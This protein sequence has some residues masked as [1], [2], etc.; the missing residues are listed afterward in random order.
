MFPF[1]AFTSADA[2]AL[3][4]QMASE[5]AVD[6]VDTVDIRYFQASIWIILDL[7]LTVGLFPLLLVVITAGCIC[8]DGGDRPRKASSVAADPRAIS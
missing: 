5:D 6:L 4:S 7:H 1:D 2:Y 8:T 3:N